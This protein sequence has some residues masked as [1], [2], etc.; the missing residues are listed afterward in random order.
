MT[1]PAPDP[2]TYA[3]ALALATAAYAA[4]KTPTPKIPVES[5]AA[6]IRAAATV[7]TR[8]QDS[9]TSAIAALWQK[10]NPYSETQVE[11]FASDAGRILVPAQRQIAQT[12]A[13]S[14][15]RQRAAAGITATAPSAIPD[16]VRGA[17]PTE[18]APEQPLAP[19]SDQERPADQRVE[20][21]RRSRVR[22][23]FNGDRPVT[24]SRTSRV[25]LRPAAEYR[26][27]RSQGRAH[28]QAN[29]A[30]VAR[31]GSIVDGNLQLARSLAERRA[32]EQAV[33][34]DREVIGYRRI[35]HP[36]LSAGGVCG[37][38][39]VAADRIYRIGQLKAIHG[40]CK[41][42]VAEVYLDFDPGGQLN[43]QDLDALY[44]AAGGNVI[45][46]L[47]RLR[48]NVVDHS[49]LGP[50]LV[51]EQGAT[52]PYLTAPVDLPLPDRASELLGV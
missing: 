30:A 2:M 19:S 23:T 36:E 18:H 22:V 21:E 38:C 11:Q 40:R 45:D 48:F 15:T 26:Y 37:M 42:T 10:T 43:G 27:A 49:E 16:D 32:L 31:V 34:L 20:P 8:I 17:L 12:T 13:A 41:C 9:T 25:M 3:Q 5:L 47:A 39:V 24:D 14:I 50:T 1:A 4:A 51:A 33:D 35:I 46:R 52:V 44:K 28:V 29:A 7:M 6:T